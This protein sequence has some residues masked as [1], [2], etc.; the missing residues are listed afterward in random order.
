VRLSHSSC[1]VRPICF[2]QALTVGRMRA[3]RSPYARHLPWVSQRLRSVSNLA[4][5]AIAAVGHRLENPPSSDPQDLLSKLQ[6]GKDES[7][8]P[9]GRDELTAEALTQLI[10]GSGA[11]RSRAAPVSLVCQSD[12]VSLPP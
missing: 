3:L 6:K 1:A 9:M 11:S 8:Q 10:A 4:K 7:G 2:E 5:I 12:P